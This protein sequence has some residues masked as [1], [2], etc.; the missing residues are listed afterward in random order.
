MTIFVVPNTEAA[1]VNSELWPVNLENVKFFRKVEVVA[2]DNAPGIQFHYV[3]GGSTNEW[4]FVN[5][6]ERDAVYDQ[7]LDEWGDE[8]G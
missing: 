2:H 5:E 4:A 3:G 6:T 8:L 7:L 1:K